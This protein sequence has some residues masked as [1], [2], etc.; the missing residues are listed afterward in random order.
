[1]V[2]SISY[3]PDPYLH[4]GTRQ[5][6]ENLFTENNSSNDQATQKSIHKIFQIY[7][8]RSLTSKSNLIKLSIH[9]KCFFLNNL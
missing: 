2:F 6:V 5:L 9:Q 7:Q 1:M 3:P 8:T 4:L